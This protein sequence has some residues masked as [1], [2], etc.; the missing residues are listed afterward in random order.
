V[1]ATLIRL[2]AALA[3]ATPALTLALDPGTARGTL[4][5]NGE[6]IAL[7]HSI[8]LRQDNAEGLLDGPELRLLL[9]DREV[10]PDA[11]A[12][13]VSWE[14]DRLGRD[15]DAKGV[16]LKFKADGPPRS[17]SGTVLYPPANPQASLPFF[18]LAGDG[19]GFKRF[20]KGDKRVVGEVEY[21]SNPEPFF[22]DMAVFDYAV[23]F[24]APVFEDLPVTATLKGKEARASAPAQA[25]LTYEKALRA[26]DLARA[27]PL[28]TPKKSRE[29]ES[30]IAQVGEAELKAQAGKM[31]PPTASRVRQIQRVVVR[32][33]RA[34]VIYKEPGTTGIQSMVQ[35]GGVWKIN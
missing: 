18:T 6:K 3:A 11:L 34:T 29:L 16:L 7:T 10:P 12:G 13:A 15:G 14:V 32:G 30:F 2:L 28:L 23:W 27:R 21:R 22:K 35:E 19:A 17:V 31:I 33:A 8:A 24:S 25:F 20:E 4:T 9:T 26:G 1:N 5:V